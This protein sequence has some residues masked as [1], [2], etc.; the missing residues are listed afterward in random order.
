VRTTGD[1]RE[2]L[3]LSRRLGPAEFE[4][5]ARRLAADPAVAEVLPDRLFFP[6]LVPNDPQYGAQWALYETHGIGAPAAWERTTGSAGVTVAIVDTG[7]LEHPDLAGRWVPGHDFVGDAQRA[8]DDD[9][10]DADATDTGDWVTPA[11]AAS[12]PLAG[13]PVTDSR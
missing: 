7:K 4:A 12:G 10:R 11:E 3:R 13:C 8:S 6:S 5:L 1:G 2:V 9:G